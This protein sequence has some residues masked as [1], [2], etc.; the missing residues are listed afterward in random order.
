MKWP[1]AGRGTVLDRLEGGPVRD[2]L[3]LN[4][5]GHD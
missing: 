4:T 5:N 2:E 3:R 1:A